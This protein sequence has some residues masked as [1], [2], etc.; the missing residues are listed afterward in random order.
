MACGCK[1]KKKV[2]AKA[3]MEKATIFSTNRAVGLPQVNA[4]VQG[5][6]TN[7][8]GLLRTEAGQYLPMSTGEYYD[9]LWSD[10]LR[11]RA[12]GWIIEVV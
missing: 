9:V 4:I 6:C 10:V 5:R 12:A 3:P 8:V 2:P 7:C 11:W 1:K